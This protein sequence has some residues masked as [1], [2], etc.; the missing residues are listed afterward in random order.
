MA[1]L[2]TERHAKHTNMQLLLVVG[3][4]RHKPK[5]VDIHEYCTFLKSRYGRIHPDSSEPIPVA[6]QQL[7]Q[8]LSQTSDAP[9]VAEQA[10]KETE[11]NAKPKRK[12]PNPKK[13]QNQN[14]KQDGSSR[15]KVCPGEIEGSITLVENPASPPESINNVPDDPVTN[16]V[17][18]HTMDIL[19]KEREVSVEDAKLLYKLGSCRANIRQRPSTLTGEAGPAAASYPLSEA[20]RILGKIL[21]SVIAHV[22]IV[23]DPESPLRVGPRPPQQQDL[24]TRVEALQVAI[25]GLLDVIKDSKGTDSRDS[26]S[27]ESC[28]GTRLASAIVQPTMAA[29]NAVSVAT[30]SQ[31]SPGDDQ[32]SF[33]SSFML[34]LYGI[35]AIILEPSQWSEASGSTLWI[36]AS[37]AA[38][39]GIQQIQDLIR[40]DPTAASSSSTEDVLQQEVASLN[41]DRSE[42]WCAVRRE[43]IRLLCSVLQL[44]FPV[45]C[46]LSSPSY[47]EASEDEGTTEMERRAG[48]R[49]GLVKS[50]VDLTTNEVERAENE[51]TMQSPFRRLDDEEW[52][53]ILRMGDLLLD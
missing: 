53:L 23:L 2:H 33:Y 31:A 28:L 1:A 7:G 42:E 15:L 3:L 10:P 17:F 48:V 46:H 25:F 8:Q 5:N 6:S 35:M 11:S 50:I 43:A 13:R 47:A 39:S 18:F 36:V 34:L 45:I 27:D 44:A 4:L 32:R 22:Q 51:G 16:P 52:Y 14:S 49:K 37:A 21:N 19:A 9:V 38:N 12:K 41:S 24:R 40:V 29:F 20:I 30:W 26:V